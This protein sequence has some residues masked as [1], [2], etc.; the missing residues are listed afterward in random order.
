MGVKSGFGAKMNL[1]ILLFW[2]SFFLVP[3]QAPLTR[4]KC[5]DGAI[6]PEKKGDSTLRILGV[7]MV[8]AL[9]LFL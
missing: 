2:A 3:E 6:E 8:S 1:V 5:R 7:L 9:S 4:T